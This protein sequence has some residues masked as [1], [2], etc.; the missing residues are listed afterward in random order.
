MR[1]PYCKLVFDH[2]GG[3]QAM[4]EKKAE[5]KADHQVN[6]VRLGEPRVHPN[7]DTLELFDIG[8]YQCVTK[9]G[10]FKP[11]DLAVYIQPDSVVPHTPAFEFLGG[12]QRI[13]CRRFRKEYSEGLLMPLSDFPEWS[14]DPVYSEGSDVSDLIGITHYEGDQ[15]VANTDGK[16]DP[17][18]PRRKY[19]RTI[20]GWFFWTLWHLGYKRSPIYEHMKIDVPK[21]DVENFKNFKNVFEAGEP[22]IVTEKLHGSQARYTYRDGRIFAGSRNFW[23]A[24][25]S[26]C[27]WW[28]ALAQNP[29]IEEYCKANEGAVLYGEVLPTQ[30]GYL[31]GNQSGEVRF[32]VFDIR[33][34][35]GEYI[36]KPYV[37]NDFHVPSG[38]AVPVLYKG[39]Y[40]DSISTLVDGISSLDKGTQREGIVIT[41][42]TPGRWARGIG[43]VQLKLKSNAFLEKEGNR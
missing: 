22:V 16:R 6:V 5:K 33:G 41:A 23:K 43:R 32:F 13:T 27:V 8:G 35:D 31:Y 10:T 25:D 2:Q 15:E 14:R 3:E 9:K 26:P 40:V 7:A 29:W 18:S 34:V 36:P 21:F 1:D 30:K 20:R 4:S 17:N 12:H 24:P 28:K 37:F 11:N 39:P 42:T 38:C 19:P